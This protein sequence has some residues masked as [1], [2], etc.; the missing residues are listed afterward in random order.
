MSAR[1]LGAKVRSI[2]RCGPLA[3][4]AVQQGRDP[5]MTNEAYSSA[6]SR[7]ARET[8]GWAVAAHGRDVA[9]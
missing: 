4:P 2:V 6:G 9:A 7:A 8:S 5:Q 3:W 1:R